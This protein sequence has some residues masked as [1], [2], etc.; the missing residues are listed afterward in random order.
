MAS[1]AGNAQCESD[2]RVD[3]RLDGS[4]LASAVA[5]P[6]ET[7][8]KLWG[9]FIPDADPAFA[10]MAKRFADG[11]MEHQTHY[12]LPQR[13]V[14]VIGEAVQEFLDAFVTASRDATRTRITIRTKDKARA[15]AERVIRKAANVIRANPDIDAEAKLLI[16][17][18]VRRKPGRRV[19]AA[20]RP[21]V[22]FLKAEHVRHGARGA[23]RTHV[24]EFMRGVAAGTRAKP[25]GAA[26]LEL[27]VGL[28]APGGPIPPVPDVR[29]SGGSDCPVCYVRSFTR[30]PMV[31]E[32]PTAWLG[33]KPM[34]VVY[35]GRWADV[36]GE[37]GPWSMAV[38]ACLEVGG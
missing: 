34:L 26:R 12:A 11:V 22:R 18:R 33:A 19:C 27:F 29:P 21:F 38:P 10:A 9:K 5:G 7:A 17:I 8:P 25:V 23:V 20:G 16:R 36:T 6:P 30:S 14:E 2:G 31:V 1:Q 4:G 32:W 35:W 13:D 3:V 15:K 24:L 28:V 37:V